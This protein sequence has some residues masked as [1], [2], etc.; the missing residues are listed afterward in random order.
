[1]S[2]IS[3]GPFVERDR[4]GFEVLNSAS[5]NDGQDVYVTAQNNKVVRIGIYTGVISF[6]VNMTS[7]AARTLALQLIKAADA[8][9]E[10]SAK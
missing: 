1:V 7:D 2:A 9:T 10:R 5:H 4:L 6:A 3:I 8:T